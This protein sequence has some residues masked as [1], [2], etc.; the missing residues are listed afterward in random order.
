M[1]LISDVG[2]GL[3]GFAS[4]FN[5]HSEFPCSSNLAI[6]LQNPAYAPSFIRT[7]I[8]HIS[9]QINRSVNYD[10]KNKILIT[11][12]AGYIGSVLTSK[13]LELGYKVTVFD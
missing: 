13:L 12:G 6:N 4:I 10:T 7:Y 5:S 11:G 1:V 3:P 2:S 8:E 9:D